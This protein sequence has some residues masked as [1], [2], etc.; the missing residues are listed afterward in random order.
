MHGLARNPASALFWSRFLHF[1]AVPLPVLYLNFTLAFLHEERPKILWSFSILAVIF[2]SLIP[3]KW[4]LSGVSPVLNFKYFPKAGPLYLP[5]LALF[6][7][8]VLMALWHYYKAM[9]TAEGQ[10]RK[11]IQTIFWGSAVGFGFG[12]TAFLPEYNFP[13]WPFGRPLVVFNAMFIAYSIIKQGFMDI[14]LLV[15]DTVIHGLTAA[16]LMVGAL[17][18]ALPLSS[19]APVVAV[20]AGVAMNTFL[21]AFAYD[22]IRRVLQPAIDRV[23]FAGRFTY[24]EE[25]GQLPNDM[26]E[27]TNLRELLKFL[28]T[29]LTEAA[30][31]ERVSIFMYDPGHQSYI[32]TM[33]H[34]ARRPEAEATLE[35]GEKQSLIRLLKTDGRFWTGEDLDRIAAPAAKSDLESL[36]GAACFPIKKDQELMGLVVLGPKRSGESF[37]QEDLKILRALRIRLENFLAQAMTITQEALNMVKDSHDMKNDINVLKGRLSW[38]ALQIASW[39]MDF[40]K[41][42]Q[43]LESWLGVEVEKGIQNEAHQQLTTAMQVLKTQALEWFSEAARSR[44]I[45]DQTIQRL[46]HRLRNWAEYGRVVSEGFRGTRAQELVE[47]G[48]VARLSV[49]RWTP[50]A[51]KKGLSL[52]FEDHGVFTVWGE[53]TLLEQITENLIDN[54]IKAT[55]KGTVVVACRAEGTEVRVD[56][57]D[58]G[59]GIP[60]EHLAT[61]FERPFYQGKGRQTLEQS[62]GVGLYLVA[63][64]A[65]SLGGRVTAES[66]FG[67]GSTFSVILPA[68][69]EDRKGTGVA[70]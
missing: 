53:R 41:Q 59:C 57:R 38:R 47:V 58:T 33:A 18:I 29:R 66:Q 61:I 62:T 55:A 24:L 48:A 52:S 1:G 46:A 16:C 15:R 37:N 56:V 32:E 39:K 17:L 6:S 28:V 26:L 27:F 64:Y 70:A 4:F 7:V 63:Q 9:K 54:A 23:V 36:K 69:R 3:T 19:I 2:L 42:M 49:E 31:L 50:I 12:S 10:L 25:L 20:L 5:Y 51:Q 21:M 11:Q 45:E 43:A 65:R 22:P 8:C 68:Y 13:V 30:K 40:D 67:S 60:P 34:D 35:I 44:S 14:R